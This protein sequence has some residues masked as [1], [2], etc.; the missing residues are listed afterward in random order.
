[1][2]WDEEWDGDEAGITRTVIY[3]CNVCGETFA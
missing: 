3:K 2:Y 1:M